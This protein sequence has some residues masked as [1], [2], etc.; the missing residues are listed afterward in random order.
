MGLNLRKESPF[1]YYSCVNWVSFIV[2]R[3]GRKNPAREVVHFTAEENIYFTYT[4]DGFAE[5]AVRRRK[6]PIVYRSRMYRVPR[7]FGRVL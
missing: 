7:H 3:S 4:A 5:C 2:R 6:D 1:S